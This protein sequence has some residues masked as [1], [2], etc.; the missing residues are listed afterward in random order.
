MRK[1]LV[2]VCGVT[3]AVLL[4]GGIAAT[5]AGADTTPDVPSLPG[6]S[7]PGMPDLPQLPDGDAQP[8]DQ[9]DL[10]ALSDP[11]DARPALPD[12]S[13]QD[14]SDQDQSDQDQ[15]DQDQSDQDQSDQ[16]QSDQDQSGDDQKGQAGDDRTGTQQRPGGSAGQD[17]RAPQ[18]DAVTSLAATRQD[19]SPGSISMSPAAPVQRQVLSLVN[20][21][22]RRG[23]CGDLTL[24]RRLIQAAFGHAADMAR[25]RYFAHESPNGEG[26]GDRVQDAGY[27]WSRYGENIARGVDSPYAV[28]D[29]WMHSPEHRA[30]ILDCRLRQMG[31]GLGFSSDRE[32]YWV[33]DFG[34]PW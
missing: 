4:A 9:G 12:Q 19:V 29:G 14:Q 28:V 18:Q 23:G 32:T 17:Q 20:Q 26:A 10:P 3:A 5:T 8:G 16:D 15:S 21:N 27:K 7:L 1:R 6:L 2:V 13:D 11:N 30:N 31:I 22:R 34:T 24:D 25:R 33:Q